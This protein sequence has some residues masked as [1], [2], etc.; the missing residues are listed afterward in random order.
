MYVCQKN[1]LKIRISNKSSTPRR[2]TGEY[3]YDD[4][5]YQFTGT[6]RSKRRAYRVINTILALLIAE[7]IVGVG[8]VTYYQDWMSFL[9][10]IM[11]PFIIGGFVVIALSLFKCGA[12]YRL[13]PAKRAIPITIDEAQS[14]EEMPNV[15]TSTL[16]ETTPLVDAS[17]IIYI[18]P[19]TSS[20]TNIMTDVRRTDSWKKRAAEYK[21]TL[22]G[23]FRSISRAKSK[24]VVTTIGL[25]AVLLACAAIQVVGC[26]IIY[27]DSQ[28]R[29]THVTIMQMPNVATFCLGFTAAVL[30]FAVICTAF[31][32]L[33]LMLKCMYNFGE[34]LWMMVRCNR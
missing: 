33:A 8:K 34:C 4:T 21:Q 19:D 32:M 2:Y 30:V 28:R 29:G 25:G 27:V 15:D 3:D 12:R 5:R 18:S 1:T 16:N 17:P 7:S 23:S 6:S 13:T 11:P 26:V 14:D 20:T 22:S 9:M 10:V 31:I 24:G